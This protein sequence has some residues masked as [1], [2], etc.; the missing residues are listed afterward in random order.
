MIRTI[1]TSPAKAV[2]VTD[3]MAAAAAPEGSYKL[4]HLDV[5]VRNGQARLASNGSIAGSTLTLDAALRYAVQ[6]AGVPLGEAIKALTQHPAA[7]LG[8]TEVGLL[9]AGKRADLLVLDPAL[10][11]QGVMRGGEWITHP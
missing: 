11:V 6:T 7:M 8:L 5:Y 3:A 4:G 10:A 9:E 1:F 2:L